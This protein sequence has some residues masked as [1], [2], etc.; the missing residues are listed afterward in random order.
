MI[1]IVAGYELVYDSI[2]RI[3]P[4]GDLFEARIDRGNKQNSPDKDKE[5]EE[6]VR[7]AIG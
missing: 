1:A 5:V 6:I 4:N 7:L 2:K 3:I